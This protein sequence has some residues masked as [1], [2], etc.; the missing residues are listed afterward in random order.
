[1]IKNE[2]TRWEENPSQ[3][4]KTQNKWDAIQSAP[5]SGVA[6]FPPQAMR[7]S[8]GSVPTA[9]SPVLWGS[10]ETERSTGKGLCEWQVDDCSC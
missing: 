1:M 5:T 8:Q 10:T 4:G 6:P 7:P 9:H 2:Q 3:L